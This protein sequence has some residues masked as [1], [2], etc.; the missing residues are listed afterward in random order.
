MQIKSYNKYPLAMSNNARKGIKLNRMVMNSCAT[1]VGKT[2]ARQLANRK[3]LSLKTISRMYSYLSRAETYYNPKN[4]LACGTISYLL[5]GGLAAKRWT[6]KIL[7]ENK[8]L[9]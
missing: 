5:W 9:K 1:P 2:R 6:G 7:K 8:L 3:P 4:K